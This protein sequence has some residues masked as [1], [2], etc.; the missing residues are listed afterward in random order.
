MFCDFFYVSVSTSSDVVCCF[1]WREVRSSLSC[2]LSASRLDFG[3]SCS[4]EFSLIPD[5]SF[6]S[7]INFTQKERLV[8]DC[9]S[10]TKLLLLMENLRLVEIKMRTKN[11]NNNSDYYS[12]FIIKHVIQFVAKFQYE[13]VMESKWISTKL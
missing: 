3:F 4:L 7:W 12:N 13:F 6:A 1:S 9:R 8:K 10:W 11:D 2:L 5:C